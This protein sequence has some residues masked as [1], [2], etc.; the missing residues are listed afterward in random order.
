M[1]DSRRPHNEDIYMFAFFQNGLTFH[2]HHF[3]ISTNRLL[4]SP[5]IP[6]FQA[7]IQHLI[8]SKALHTMWAFPFNSPLNGMRT[9]PTLKPR[10]HLD[11]STETLERASKIRAMDVSPEAPITADPTA[12]IKSPMYKKGAELIRMVMLMK[13]MM[14]PEIRFMGPNDPIANE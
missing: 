1:K 2:K 8:I 4:N 5:L 12:M 14:V 13:Y 3:F 6:D 9:K 11:T 10:L 7:P